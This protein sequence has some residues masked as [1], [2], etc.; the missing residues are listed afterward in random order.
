MKFIIF[1]S[2]LVIIQGHHKPTTPHYTT[3]AKWNRNYGPGDVVKD[4]NEKRR[5]VGYPELTHSNDLT[6]DCEFHA[7]VILCPIIGT[8][9][10]NH[11]KIGLFTFSIWLN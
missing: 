3:P 1:C 8:I 11:I 4:I 9:I 10:N 2:V 7:N 5:S 6:N